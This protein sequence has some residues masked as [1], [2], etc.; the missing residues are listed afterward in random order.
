MPAPRGYGHPRNNYGLGPSRGPRVVNTRSRGAPGGMLPTGGS[1]GAISSSSGGG[2]NIDELLRRLQEEQSNANN[3]GLARYQSLLETVGGAQTSVLGPGGTLDRAD[4]LTQNMGQTARRRIA[5]STA[6]QLGSSEQD[7]T[8]RG[9]G[10]TTIRSNV[11]QGI[12]AGAEQANQAVDEQVSTARAG[13]LQQRAGTQMDFARLMGDSIL[14]RNDQGPDMGMYANLLAQL[15]QSGGATASGA[16]APT[17]W[18]PHMGPMPGVYWSDYRG[19]RP[20]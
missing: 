11:R 1:G 3:A 19:P 14:S 16:A 15:S 9:L 10:N 5:D 8:S 2:L 18:Q 12:Q 7:L 20:L 6:Q 17:S 4:E 13:Q